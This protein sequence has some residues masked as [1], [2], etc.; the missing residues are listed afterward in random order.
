M[1]FHRLLTLALLVLT[2]V[3]IGL[4]TASALRRGWRLVAARRHES[5]LDAVRPHVLE[6]LAIADP[7]AGLVLDRALLRGRSD[8]RSV[9]E[10]VGGL[11]PKLRGEDRRTLA[12]DLERTGALRAGP[13][14]H[15]LTA[16]T[17]ARRAATLVG[18][19]QWRRALPELV[20]LLR[21]AD[22]EVRGVAA[23]A[24]GRMGAAEAVPYLLG[25]LEAPRRSIS[26]SVVGIALLHLGPASAPALVGGLGAA[27]A[28]TRS[29]V[30]EILG[31]MGAQDAVDHL[32]RQLIG[33]SE[34]EP[35]T[36]AAHALGRIGSPDA[37]DGL[38]A[39]LS[40]QEA[41]ALRIAAALA[42]G[43]IGDPAAVDELSLMM[44]D[45]GHRVARRGRRCARRARGGR[46]TDPSSG[47]PPRMGSGRPVPRKELDLRGRVRPLVAR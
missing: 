27:P 19:A 38:V 23:R 5:T 14:P 35:R 25:A 1:E 10:L 8:E 45:P 37:F 22:V 3:I 20:W 30:A 46:A 16:T 43:R 11:L 9:E 44:A 47:P 41:P 42:L 13:T 15:V 21:D 6:R 39:A 2:L 24:I 33:D 29:L 17:G 28:A 4:S 32:C 12:R 36:A 31:L 7:E 34:T 40:R 18:A 26:T